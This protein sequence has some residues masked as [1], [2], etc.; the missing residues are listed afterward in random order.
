MGGN[1]QAVPS[2]SML[3]QDIGAAVEL[4]TRTS[5]SN[6]PRNL[7]Y[8][9][10][11]EGTAEES[12]S[13][14]S[15]D[16]LE[17][18]LAL[19][20]SKHGT[21][22]KRRKWIVPRA[23]GTVRDHETN[24]KIKF[25]AAKFDQLVV[26]VA[27]NLAEQCQRAKKRKASS[28]ASTPVGHIHAELKSSPRNPTTSMV[29]PAH[30]ATAIKNEPKEVRF[31]PSE[32]ARLDTPTPANRETKSWE[33]RVRLHRI[34]EEEMQRNGTSRIPDQ[35]IL[36]DS[37]AAVD[38]WK[39]PDY[40]PSTPLDAGNQPAANSSQSS[41]PPP[42]PDKDDNAL[43]QARLS[44]TTRSSFRPPED[45][46]FVTHR[47]ERAHGRAESRITPL[48]GYSP[49]PRIVSRLEE[50]RVRLDRD[51]DNPR[52]PPSHH[53]T[54]RGYEMPRVTNPPD[55][56][57]GMLGI[58][59]AREHHRSTM[60]DRLTRIMDDTIGHQLTF[61]EGYKP[62]FKGDRGDPKKYGGSPKMVDLEEWL[63][64]TVYR[65]A[66]QKLGG[67]EIE[68]DRVRVML[69]IDSLEGA[70]YK[71]MMKHVVHVT[72][73]VQYWTFRDVIHGLY[74][75]FVHPSS[76][77]DARENLYKV[78]YSAKDGIQGL[79]DCMQEHA[80]GMAVFPDD[81]TLLSIFLDKIPP[82]M[83]TELLN[84][85][86][87]TPEINS[88]SEFV[89]HALDIEQ[90]KKNEQ[91]YKDRRMGSTPF[92]NR[93]DSK[94]QQ[95]V[96]KPNRNT[97]A[98]PIDR[99]DDRPPND[100][101]PK[102]YHFNNFNNN[103]SSNSNNAATK[104]YGP[105]R[106]QFQKT[107]Q[108]ERRN[109][110]APR[111]GKNKY[112]WSKEPFQSNKPGGDHA[113]HPKRDYDKFKKGKAFVRAARS[114]MNGSGE[115]SDKESSDSSNASDKGRMSPIPEGDADNEQ[116]PDDQI[117]IEVS[118]YYEN[119]DEED[120]MFAMR[121]VERQEPATSSEHDM[122]NATVVFPLG[123]SSKR[124]GIRVRRHK[125]IPSRKTRIRPTLSEEEKRCLATWVEINGLKAWTLWDSGS[126]TTGIT[127][128]FAE[129]AQIAVDELEDPHVL[130]LG[131][132]G[133][134]SIIKYGADVMT[135]VA[136]TRI[137]T[138]VDIANFDRYEMIIGTP[139]M[140][141][142]KV[143]LDF[144]KL[145]VV[146][147]GKRVPAILV[148]NGKLDIVTRRQRVTEKKKE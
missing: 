54:F 52:R 15:L 41:S 66:L 117:E 132:V 113:D 46:G 4:T 138:Y 48:Q 124:P 7:I 61:P 8:A 27:D 40:N 24:L 70:A 26:A 100:E 107:K 53:G 35:G 109:S 97:Y 93:R 57:N 87:L 37:N 95:E 122:L 101:K 63:S 20:W 108:P 44:P 31:Q 43:S 28:I 103:N 143:N 59:T 13:D 38:L 126:T 25:D 88:L 140:I 64:A 104:S 55:R 127:P 99:K 16:G 17:Y 145:E 131:T 23:I 39:Y 81:Y 65:M 21:T 115:E 142:N 74:D 80:G 96:R 68:I 77:Q 78:E 32:S 50:T 116:E 47:E 133:S 105:N 6:S 2:S 9:G 11:A 73:R 14:E 106:N 98:R 82:Y 29:G 94:P 84:T 22:E 139:F 125:L 49:Q 69:L 19:V 110:P 147:Q 12:S 112:Q 86:G 130:Q 119:D 42:V 76:M 71:W 102:L 72:R 141:K 3:L 79:Y 36:Y 5:P 135:N 89:G 51:R 136:G 67:Q 56:F 75:R 18:A 62:T 121:T 129:L 45:T 1:A 58:K 118:E 30:D 137:S 33:E 123:E 34:R 128:A 111:T 114:A 148:P 144:D 83:V 134:R 85:R 146:I 120:H 10:P 90:R 92:R 91:Y 60:K